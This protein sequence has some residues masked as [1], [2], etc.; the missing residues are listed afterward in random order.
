M[1]IIDGFCGIGAWARRDP[2]L[3]CEPAATLAL[4][5]YFGI[6]KALVYGMLIDQGWGWPADANRQAAEAA[7]ACDRFIPMLIP[8]LHAHEGSASLDTYFE[9]ARRLKAGGVWI[10]PPTGSALR[11]YETWLI[12]A[13]LERC[14]ALRLPAFFNVDGTDMN[15]VHRLCLDFPD[16]RLVLTGIGYSADDVLFPLLVRHENLHVCLGHFY[17]PSGGPVQFLKKFPAERLLFGSGLPHFSPGG[18]IGHVRY[19]PIPEADKALILC[20]NLQR[21]LEERAP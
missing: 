8:G 20:G 19:A 2:I 15:V 17:I 13:I 4:M 16:L 18:L 21:L 10:K 6:R 3:P 12:G 5:D 11:N 14:V 9:A 7:A 1:E